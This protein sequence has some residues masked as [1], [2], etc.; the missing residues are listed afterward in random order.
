MDEDRKNICKLLCKKDC[1]PSDVSICDSKIKQICIGLNNSFINNLNDQQVSYIISS[2]EDNVYLEACPGSGKT[3]V[4]AL[5]V[6][7]EIYKWKNEKKGMA[8]LTFTNSAEKEIEQRIQKYIDCNYYYPHF[9]GTFTSW[10]HKYVAAPFLSQLINF[11]KPLTIVD[12]NTSSSF[13]NAFKTKYA[14]RNL[15]HIRANQFNKDLKNNCYYYTGKDKELF[16]DLLENDNENDYRMLDLHKTKNKFWQKGFATYDDMEFLSYL[17]LKKH[18]NIRKIIINRFPILFI[19]ECQDLSFIE[20]NLLELLKNDGMVIHLI[21]DL[22]QAIYQFRK[23][24]PEDTRS[25][26]ES[27][28]FKTISLDKNYRSGQTIVN[29]SNYVIDYKKQII[30]MNKEIINSPL[31]IIMYKNVEIIQAIEKYEKLLASYGLDVKESRIIVR[32][33]NLKNKLTGIDTLSHSYNILEELVIILHLLTSKSVE[34]YKDAFLRTG[35]LLQKVYF[36]DLD[37]LNST[38]FYCPKDIESD[39][40]KKKI[41]ITLNLLKSDNSLYD[42]DLKWKVW[43]NKASNFFQN[44]L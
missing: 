35:R 5:K 23:I 6:V 26:I 42:F 14:F 21:G 10:L 44:N 43:R 3:E 4:L 40:W 32:N 13:L 28:N 25:F 7:S 41:G 1:C 36:K 11:E 15:G 8:I 22:N 24:E 2:I 19:D 17:L 18:K 39:D 30:G 33:N 9:I 34:S 20:L 37:H 27:N 38:Y 31:K 12:D 29:I 16:N